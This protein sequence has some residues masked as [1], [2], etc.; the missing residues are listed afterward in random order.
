MCEPA[1]D[2][3]DPTDAETAD[4]SDHARR[5][6][7]QLELLKQAADRRRHGA[8]I[9]AMLERTTSNKPDVGAQRTAAVDEEDDGG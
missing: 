4:S 8:Y 6:R 2:S 3:A 5:N 7:S 1:D 9:D